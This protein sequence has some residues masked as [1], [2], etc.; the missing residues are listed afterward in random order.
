MKPAKFDYFAPTQ[1]VDALALIADQ[2]DNSR[3][4]AG[5]QSLVSMMN[6]RMA[7]PAALIDLN[8]IAEGV[9]TERLGNNP[10]SFTRE[11]I[12]FMLRDL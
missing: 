10:R 7:T 11:S 3:F 12:L 8:G 9:N 6:F 4:L 1:I 5:G 2:G